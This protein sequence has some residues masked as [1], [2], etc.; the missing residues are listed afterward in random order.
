MATTPQM[1]VYRPKG[2][3]PTGPNGQL[4]A[5]VHRRGETGGGTLYVPKDIFLLVPAD[6]RFFCELTEEGI[7][8]RRVEAGPA[9]PSWAKA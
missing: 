6:A 7:L 4:L 8:F 1:R 9:L 5:S 3:R 2:G